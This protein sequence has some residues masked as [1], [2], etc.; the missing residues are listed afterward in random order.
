MPSEAISSAEKGQLFLVDIY[1]SDRTFHHSISH[2]IFSSLKTDLI[3][4]IAD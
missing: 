4:K 2:S 3:K 1:T